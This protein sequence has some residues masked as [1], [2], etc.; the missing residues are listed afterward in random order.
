MLDPHARAIA[1][2][3]ATLILLGLVEVVLVADGPVR[4]TWMVLLFPVV[5]AV[6]L[7][8][9]TAAA[10]RRPN[11]RTGTLLLA[12]AVAW[13]LAGLANTGQPA[14][15]AAGLVCATLPIAV[16]VHLLLGFP[17]GRLRD[18]ASRA[19]VA[20][21]YV[22]A[23]VL[24]A[25]AY[26]F[27]AGFAGPPY[28]TLLVADRP[29]LADTLWWV[30]AAGGA[31]VVAATVVLLV[32]HARAGSPG[33][34]RVLAPLYA[35]GIV[36]VVF[37]LASGQVAD[38][39]VPSHDDTR[40]VLQ[41]ALFAG[42]P[43]AFAA[44]VLLGGFARM[45]RIEE[46]GAWLRA[47]RPTLVEAL[48]RTLGDPSLRLVL[49]V[50]PAGGYVDFAGAPVT[51]PATGVAEVRSDG[52]LIGAL[53]YD[54]TLL[55]ERDDVEAAARMTAIALDHERLTV[56][57]TA[58]RD[59]LR[60]SRARIVAAG[61]EERRRIARDLHD[62]LQSRL[63]LLAIQAGGLDDARALRIGLEGAV[64]ELRGLV[65]GVLPAALIERGLPA[66][67]EDLA[68]RLPVPTTLAVDTGLGKLPDP[69]AVTG[70]FVVA[71]ALTNAVKHGHA[72]AL[73]VDLERHGGDLRIEIAD[74]GVGGA[75][76]G[77]GTGMRGMADRVDVLG[78][79]L[80]IVSPPGGGTRVVAEVP[81][82]S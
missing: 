45:G 17:S 50:P 14:L 48:R 22:V 40:A 80:T 28:T 19:T 34:R 1:Q 73:R 4:P 56:E 39:V 66:A 58:G 67:V 61:D 64:A 33:R 2:L 9:G 72:H 23:L 57:L 24:Q 74:D 53:V 29:G 25:P 60:R 16:V 69:V 77:G 51:L 62:G 59:E 21:G 20:A 76:A 7:A 15:V 46:L 44:S 37:A 68:D 11:N 52:R 82:V 27:G 38:L 47:A 31:L 63:V 65:Q 43:V 8:A 10:L 26:L 75:A 49:W 12:G 70:Y 71:E 35:Y 41:L 18:R 6:Y 32:R 13:L 81:C 54:A 30:Q 79:R 36:A 55:A 78:G 5:A 42:I 3:A